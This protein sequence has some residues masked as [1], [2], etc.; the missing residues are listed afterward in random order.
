VILCIADSALLNL[1]PETSGA[2]GPDRKG[3]QREGGRVEREEVDGRNDSAKNRD[4]RGPD[5]ESDPER[6]IHQGIRCL[7]EIR[8][9]GQ[10]RDQGAKRRIEERLESRRNDCHWEQGPDRNPKEVREH[11][12]E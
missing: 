3:G 1:T 4:Y 10:R 7:R 11:R 8:I 2:G 5:H 12:R 9:G 6:H